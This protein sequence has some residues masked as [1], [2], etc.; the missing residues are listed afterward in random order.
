MRQPFLQLQF[1]NCLQLKAI[2]MQ[3][4]DILGG[5]FWLPSDSYSILFNSSFSY[6]VFNWN[7][8]LKISPY[9]FISDAQ[10][11]GFLP[12]K[13]SINPRHAPCPISNSPFVSALLV[14][15]CDW[16]NSILVKHTCLLYFI[17]KWILKAEKPTNSIYNMV[18]MQILFTAM[19][20]NLFLYK[21]SILIHVSLKDSVGDGISFITLIDSSKSC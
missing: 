2:S 16:L 19:G 1:C 21:S 18:I 5:M 11:L 7:N 20:H 3:K 8:K 10:H 14:H 6:P 9:S 12:H 13:M 15:C 4:W 17:C